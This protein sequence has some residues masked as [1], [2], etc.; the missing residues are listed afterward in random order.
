MPPWNPSLQS[1][2]YPCPFQRELCYHWP[3]AGCSAMP[4]FCGGFRRWLVMVLGQVVIAPVRLA[5][6]AKDGNESRAAWSAVAA[7]SGS[8]V[9]AERVGAVV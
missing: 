4:F 8:E 5:A 1:I 2:L 9:C 6:S 3:T 7:A